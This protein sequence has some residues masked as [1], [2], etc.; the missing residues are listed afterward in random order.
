VSEVDERIVKMTFDNKQFEEASKTTLGT[1]DK[2][3]A[4]LN[5]D[6]VKDVFGNISASAS[7][8]D[9]TPIQNGAE[10]VASKF[11]ALD[12]VAFTVMQNI[13]NKAVNAGE[14]LVSA[15]TI[16]PIKSG[17]Q[18]YQTQIGAIQTIM[19]NTEE[20][21][22]GISRD[23]H[24]QAVNDTLA[25]LNTYADKTIYNFTEMTKNIGT[26]TAAGVDLETSAG[27]IQ[28]IANM[29]A[30]SGSTSQQA[31]TAMYQLSQALAAGTVKLQD[32]NSVVNAGMGGK[33]FQNKLIEVSEELGTGAQQYIDA[34]GSFRES[35]K[36]GW[37]TSE[38][39]AETLNRATMKGAIERSVR[40]MKEYANASDEVIKA[41]V[42]QEEEALNVAIANGQEEQ[43]YKDMIARLS[44][45]NEL[46]AETVEKDIT[47]ARNAQDA[48]TKVRTFTALV[49][50]LKEAM[51]SGWT[52]T[53]SI[54]IG[55]FDQ[56][57]ELFTAISN[58]LGAIIQVFSDSRNGAIQAWADA[59]GRKHL[60]GALR[61]LYY[62]IVRIA[63]PISK[64]WNMVFPP[65][66]DEKGFRVYYQIGY[67][68]KE[69]TKAV[70]LFTRTLKSSKEHQDN[71]QKTFEVIFT[72][73]KAVTTVL[74]KFV[75]V[76][77]LVFIKAAQFASEVIFFLTSR[78]WYFKDVISG[79]A[80]F[81]TAPLDFL[82]GLL[83]SIGDTT[84]VVGMGFK[85]IASAVGGFVGVIGS[86]I[87]GF[88][89]SIKTFF[90]TSEAVLAVQGAFRN[91]VTSIVN[92][93]K[94]ATGIRI[95]RTLANFG[96]LSDKGQAA[97][98]NIL[99]LIKPLARFAGGAIAKG[100]ETVSGALATLF[101]A[102]S[103]AVGGKT[104]ALFEFIRNLRVAKT[105]SD[106]LGSL[107]NVRAAIGSI[108][109]ESKKTLKITDTLKSAVTKIKEFLSKAFKVIAKQGEGI[110]TL[111]KNTFVN[112]FVNIKDAFKKGDLQS[113]SD[114]LV[115][116]IMG[117]SIVKLFIMF[118]NFKKN[119]KG[120]ASAFTDMLSGVTDT[121]KAVQSQIKAEILSDIAK[122]IA[123]LVAS[124]VVLSLI[125]QEALDKAIR[126]IITLAAV[127]LAFMKVKDSIQNLGK[128][129]DDSPGLGFFSNISS[130]ISD[131]IK[132]YKA[133]NW[134]KIARA[135]ATLAVGIFIIAKAVMA[136]AQLDQGQLTRGL[137]GVGA[138]MAALAL[139]AWWLKK[140]GDVVNVGF[141]IG[142]IGVANGISKIAK[143]IALLA[144]IK[145]TEKMRN[146]TIAI[147]A[148]IAAMGL[149]LKIIGDPKH[150]LSIGIGMVAMSVAIIA[151]V[152][153]IALMAKI[154]AKARADK[155]GESVE[156][157]VIAAAVIASIMA[158]FA[159][160]FK[161]MDP[162]QMT[163]TA[164][165]LFAMGI[166]LYLVI[167]A[168]VAMMKVL[169]KVKDDKQMGMLIAAMAAIAG[170]ML[171]MAV[172]V[173]IMG[174]GVKGVG[175]ATAII[176]IA[177]ALRI[178]APAIQMLSQC[179]L[180][181]VV[182]GLI[183]IA[184][185][186]VILAVAAIALQNWMQTIKGLTTAFLK[187]SIGV[188]ALSVALLLLSPAIVKLAGVL[189][190]AG[191][192]I[193]G[194]LFAILGAIIAGLG[195]MIG[196]IIGLVV[197][198]GKELCKAIIALAPD[199]C[200]AIA[201]LLAAAVYAIA[202]SAYSIAESLVTIILAIIDVLATYINPIVDRVVTLIIN[203][204]LALGDNIRHHSEGVVKAITSVCEAIIEITISVIEGLLGS[205]PV[206]GDKV[207][208]W[209]KD[210]KEELRKELDDMG[211]TENGVANMEK[212]FTSYTDIANRNAE[213]MKSA[214][215]ANGTAF[216]DGL[217]SVTQNGNPLTDT[218]NGMMDPNA[219]K[220]D[221][222]MSKFSELGGNIDAG[223]GGGV[224]DNKDLVT[225]PMGDMI[226]EGFDVMELVSDT[227][228]PSVRGEDLGMNIDLGV[229]QGLEE[230]APDVKRAFRG[231][232]VD[233]FELTKVDK[234]KIAKYGDQIIT[235]LSDA[236]ASNSKPGQEMRTV[237]SKFEV[238]LIKLESR[239][240]RHGMYAMRRFAM[241]VHSYAP[242]AYAEMRK[243]KRNLI[244]ILDGL[245][246]SFEAAGSNT[247][248]GLSEGIK[249]N[250]EKVIKAG[251]TMAEQIREGY[252]N[253][254]IIASPAKA[255]RP[256]A[257]YTVD[258]LVKQ[259]E[260]RSKD[261]KEAGTN[262]GS[263]LEGGLFT[264]LMLMAAAVDG[265]AECDPVI[266]PVVDLSGIQNGADMIEG[267][268]AQRS[269]ML[270]MQLGDYSNGQINRLNA[271][272]ASID[273]QDFDNSDVVRAVNSMGS[274]I[275][276][277]ESAIMNMRVV[278]DSG[279]IVGVVDQGIGTRVARRM[280]GN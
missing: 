208:A 144:G 11:K 57:T 174:G 55:D 242:L 248:L 130:S 205:I 227:H 165:A 240:Q 249:K 34:E 41:R 96:T 132:S 140:N 172:A 84:T 278:L 176:A 38:V 94:N 108:G 148:V 89:E 217:K 23:D 212:T 50:T 162:K 73:I 32:W 173:K 67:V 209:A 198:L 47:F 75:K 143:A 279:T 61:G 216:I 135:L 181:D 31:S 113:I 56:A 30:M 192:A 124:I 49:D 210:T 86:A 267:M 156:N 27:A 122:S 16:D 268:M 145:D 201:A 190:V 91:L 169:S 74:G 137:I 21:F 171:A 163:G 59:N 102:A 88:K 183:L 259:I 15:F 95:H 97:A 206:I 247:V 4:S 24:L 76:G 274:R 218:I 126:A 22:E 29:A 54:L 133:S 275:D 214:G 63:R 231:T 269:Y 187:I 179:K 19:S 37:I 39:L 152:G 114:I 58:K 121:L 167:G 257:D 62:S 245:Y 194:A 185:A 177:I 200:D 189:A 116:G 237:I 46:G 65:E 228:S 225:K 45:Y 207:V 68:L 2:L 101:N 164:A 26:F 276:K 233:L 35:L 155:T 79:I 246:E 241:G 107:T 6:R 151:I 13:T 223:V 51:Q 251:S 252:N 8:V 78:L 10:T 188:L 239:F 277:L 220:L 119:T 211:V 138:I 83:L 93:F 224:F 184:G 69:A 112:S 139:M 235:A 260:K 127:I 146:G 180:G 28:G 256:L 111:L 157:L 142:F 203:F 118:R 44:E 66:I 182:K 52:Q 202:A 60:L 72:I 255:M 40:G 263:S 80:S 98:E 204:F 81:I 272:S 270:T 199:V 104:D 266:R 229:A 103:N 219:L 153:A 7:K 261:A 99:R 178:L 42:R 191:V 82:M 106:K 115:N 253:E 87:S 25:E 149:A 3:K 264:A 120:I 238:D 273:A 53:W 117:A 128:D 105:E 159:L 48:A 262:L 134:G 131:L 158:I 197:I 244:S 141:G 92:F 109:E 123:I 77:I 265:I 161:L 36:N 196:E 230:G 20:A 175:A 125:D 215:A 195:A 12:V 150:M 71:I 33:L 154:I 9:L 14:K 234:K 43:G 5:F 168:I 232:V 1:L 85:L 243:V 258:G 186:F 226:S 280:R 250:S 100:I 136:L 222:D 221:L 64:A 271:I 213:D 70:R 147:I 170:M 166:S 193:V 129:D 110:A 254:M 236:I 160:A 18:E 90:N 17:L